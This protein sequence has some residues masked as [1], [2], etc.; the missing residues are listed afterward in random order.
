MV[1]TLAARHLFLAL[2]PA[3]PLQGLGGLPTSG[4]P[5]I[6]PKDLT[7]RFDVPIGLS[8]KLWAESPKLYNPT[9]IDVDSQGRVWVAEGVNY[10]KWGGR[11]P[12]REHP[13]GE[14][15]VI[16]GDP[17]GNAVATTS[18][19]FVQ[20]PD[21]VVPLGICV[22]GA[23]VFVSCS[24]NLYVYT[25]NDQ[26]G[27]SDS[28]ATFL[29]GFGGHDHD[30]GLHS[31]VLGPDMSLWFNTGNAGPHLVA[32][33]DGWNLR[34]GSLYRD[35]GAQSADNRPGLVSDDG[36]VWTG[37]LVLRIDP[38]GRGL[39][40]RAHNFRNNYELALDSYGNVY[41]SDNDDDGN[42]GCRALWCMEGANHGYFSADGSRTWVS[43]RRPGQDTWTAHWHQDDPGVAPAGT[44][45]GAGGPTGVAVYESEVLG[46]DLDGRVLCADA[47]AG[48]VYALRPR[49][50]GAGIELEPGVLIA[51]KADAPES[52]RA[53]WFRPSDVAVGPDGTIFVADWS[54]PGVGGHAAGDREAYGRILRIVPTG[55]W[56]YPT[57]LELSHGPGRIE[58]LANPAPSVRGIVARAI[59]A[60]RDPTVEA[61]LRASLGNTEK[62]LAARTIWIAARFERLVPDVTRI[63]LSHEEPDLRITAVR[64]L[65]AAGV[66]ILQHGEKLAVD[67]SPAVRRELAV[68]LRGVPLEKSRAFLLA[69]ARGY[70]GADRAYLEAFG[71]AAEGHEAA[72]WPDLVRELGHED[73]LRWSPRFAG[74]AWRLHPEAA[75]PGF[76]ARARTDT[77]PL[78]E[79][80]RTIDG[81]AF[82]RSRAA[83]EA[84]V[85]L[86]ISGPEDTRELARWWVLDRDQNDW[87]GFDLARQVG[88]ADEKGVLV[89]S[90]PIVRKGSVDV[91]VDVTGAK[92]LW[93][94]ATE[95]NDGQSA[96]WI[97]WLEPRV[98]HAGGIAK[99][100]EIPWVRADAAWGQTQ[101]GKNCTGG[102]IVVDGKTWAEGLGS[103]AYSV[104][105]FD[106]PAGSTRFTAKAAVD[107][108]GSKQGRSDV[109]FQVLLDEGV[110]QARVRE[111][112]RVL[113]N[114]DAANADVE[115]AAEALCETREGGLEVIRLAKTGKL[116]AAAHAAVSKRIFRSPDLAVR[117]LASAQF[118]RAT[119][120]GTP[121]PSVAELARMEGS[122]ARGASLFFGQATCAQCHAFHG[123][124]A[125][126][127][128]DLSAV[129]QKYAREGLLDAMLNPSASIAFGYD[130]WL[131][132]TK[133][134]E[135]YTGFVVRDGDEL[136][137]RD[138]TGRRHAIPSGEI[139]TRAR[140][141][142]SAMP[143]GVALGLGPQEI[144]DVLALLTSDPTAPGTP[145]ERVVLFDGGDLSQWTFHLSDPAKGVAD[146]W[147]VQD[148]ILRCSGSPAG[149]LKTKETFTNFVLELDW[150]FDATKGAG[151]SGVLLRRTGPDKVWP[152]S[153]EAQLMSRNAGDIWNIDAVP[154]VVAPER[155]E[156]RHTEK[157]RP[158]NEKPLGEWNHYKITLDGGE[159]T[160]EVNGEVQNRASWCEEIAGEICLQSEGAWIEFRNVVLT[161]LARR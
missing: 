155:T 114:A 152:R 129:R 125:D 113:S 38:N 80:R 2:A 127:G 3:L 52:E 43:D 156:G 117:A 144:A 73:P 45:L 85:D 10:R 161:K 139:A 31:V 100:A 134:E 78:A 111:L 47:G 59:A 96:D 18:Q 137:L 112:S 12:G 48:K 25:D 92:K 87:K 84:M 5:V 30:H 89:W 71:L 9:A 58:A 29:T 123:R 158:S 142:V 106:L 103:H 77:L 36:R 91:D 62:R 46:Y 104:T 121:L 67:K 79:R 14:R 99:L 56:I 57:K 76:A 160:L 66:D 37:G 1:T 8:V 107:D 132:E 24:P 34:S 95:G 109:E 19:V 93:L 149:Y 64:A 130:T 110:L 97:D 63:A 13:G 40:V 135:L 27:V 68:A 16:L 122:A 136:V 146:V 11:N 120:S 148:G 74:L 86:A 81:L 131:V 4:G 35:G 39:A 72:L 28:R 133:D 20:D 138:T 128:P 102:P 94:V 21:L 70:D 151:N 140:Q 150:R 141:T 83:G 41:Q 60:E 154:M 82:V 145:G 126:I 53:G 147:S 7:S 105:E 51:A 33:K 32:D 153:I 61:R 124:G 65:R 49:A 116:S 101:R 90:S 26:D 108:S 115:A 50:K 23:R 88:G 17:D 15:I 6:A 22:S 119:A 143:D 54:D 44:R 75:V 98:A 159:L 69:L 157:L 55:Q 42:Q 118:E